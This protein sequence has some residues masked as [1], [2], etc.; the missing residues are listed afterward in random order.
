MVTAAKKWMWTTL[1]A[2]FLIGAGAG[3]LLARIL[4]IPTVHSNT[5]DSE[6]HDGSHRDHSR[7]MTERLRSELDLTA[8]QA[9]ALEDV[10]NKNHEIAREFWRESRLEFGELRQQFRQ[11]I[12]STLTEEQKQRFDRFV[13]TN[14]AR[15]RETKRD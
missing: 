6:R 8:E 13:E 12:R 11:D 4:L 5:R 2:T 7:R 1:V 15:P 3:I 10:M 9:A 14:A